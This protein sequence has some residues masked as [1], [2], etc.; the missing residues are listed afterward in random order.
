MPTA[1][2]TC[3]ENNHQRIRMFKDSDQKGCF[4]LLADQTSINRRLFVWLFLK[5][6]YSQCSQVVYHDIVTSLSNT[7]VHR[8]E[9]ELEDLFC[10][11]SEELHCF[12]YPFFNDNTA[13][14]TSMQNYGNRQPETDCPFLLDLVSHSVSLVACSVRTFGVVALS[15]A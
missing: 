1:M 13:L 10:D 12:F 11:N 5:S 7:R 14:L 3:V 15:V 9:A 6:M 4:D 2:R 8:T